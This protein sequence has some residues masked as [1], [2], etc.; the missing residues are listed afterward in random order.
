MK[1]KPLTYLLIVS[2]AAVWGIIFYRIFSAS[3]ND[4]IELKPIVKSGFVNESLDDYK[5]KDTFILALNYKDP[6]LGKVAEVAEPSQAEKPPVISSPAVFSNPKPLKPQTNWEVVKY[7]GFILNSSG[8]QVVAL[9]TIKGKEQ[10]LL[11]GQTADGVKLLKNLKDSV[12]VLYQDQ[13]KFIRL[14]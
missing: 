9:M 5:F 4:E 7:T 12:K 14:K 8:K 13:T 3:D 6:F 10:M 1:N 2:V 11:E